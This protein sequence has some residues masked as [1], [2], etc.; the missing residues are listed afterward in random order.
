[1][2]C[3]ASATPFRPANGPYLY[4]VSSSPNPWVRFSAPSGGHPPPQASRSSQIFPQKIFRKI[5]RLVLTILSSIH[6]QKTGV[7][8]YTGLHP[9]PMERTHSPGGLAPS[10]NAPRAFWNDCRLEDLRRAYTEKFRSYG[11]VNT[12]TNARYKLCRSKAVLQVSN[13]N[14]FPSPSAVL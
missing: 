9:R 2:P 13:D 7:L 10:A 12:H 5:F 11:F 3:S 1:M 6:H 8:A 4:T 14:I